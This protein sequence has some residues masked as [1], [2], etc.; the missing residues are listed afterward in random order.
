[1]YMYQVILVCTYLHFLQQM[2]ST[3]ATVVNTTTTY[4]EGQKHR[5][6]QESQGVKENH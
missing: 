2:I 3:I 1:M 6:T 5:W 4:I